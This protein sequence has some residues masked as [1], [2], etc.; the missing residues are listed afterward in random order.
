MSTMKAV[1]IHN[2]GPTNTLTY[3]EV[4][5]PRAGEGEILIRNFATSVNPF[6]CAVRAGYVTGWYTYGFPLTLG[7]DISGIVEEVGAGA[8]HFVPGDAVWAR[9]DPALNGAYAEFVSV[10]ASEI[11]A[12]PKSLDHVD[13]AALPHVGVTAWR[14]L[15]DTANL[16]EGQSVLIHA[17][18]GGVGS[19]AVQLAKARGAKV[20][21]TASTA[22]LDF[23]SALGADEIID[24][25]KTRFEDVVHDVDVVM[26]N[27][28][29]ETQERSWA[30]LKPGGILISIVQPPSEETAAKYGV[31][32]QFA[33]GYPPVG[34]VL[35]DIA[36]M[37]DAGKIKPIIATVHPLSEVGKAHELVEAHHTR[38]KQIVQ[39]A[40]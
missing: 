40:D 27:V 6:D 38:G 39:I 16:T 23:L 3:E 18:A 31:R 36:A 10:S 35:A 25:T 1:R 26:D 32:Q 8:N 21:G 37:V 29:G 4:A 20:I 7:L 9:S 12:K 34:P 2:Y 19:F 33:G 5:K 24:Y 13:A 22:N 11:A 15:V 14:V 28:G 30:V 17:A